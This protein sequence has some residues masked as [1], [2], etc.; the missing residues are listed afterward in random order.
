L[1]VFTASFAPP[2]DRTPEPIDVVLFGDSVSLGRGASTTE[3]GFSSIIA[4]R[5][6]G[7]GYQT[8]SRTVVSALGG[9]YVD[10]K[11]TPEAVSAPS[12]LIVVEVG[13][14]S[15]I[16]NQTMPLATYRVAYGMILDCLQRSAAQIVVGTVPSLNWTPGSLLYARASA[17][18]EIIREEA[19]S[20]GVGVA[21]LWSVTKDRPDLVSSD[22]MHPDDAG[23]RIIAD[24]YWERIQPIIKR[25][26]S[27]VATSCDYSDD[28]IR[29]LLG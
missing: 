18:S 20:R 22:G 27:G 17:M 25:P 7:L 2:A 6:D 21:D 24:A 28:D 1:F 15:V 26:A 8:Q 14:H 29:R 23:H 4:Q 9:V 11:E 5:L 19:D 10:L 3:S 13:A 12:R 16:E